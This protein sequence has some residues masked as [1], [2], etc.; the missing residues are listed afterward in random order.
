M[1]KRG[2]SVLCH[3]R[4]AQTIGVPVVDVLYGDAA[5]YLTCIRFVDL[6]IVAFKNYFD[7]WDCRAGTSKPLGEWSQDPEKGNY[8]YKMGIVTL[9]VIPYSHLN[10]KLFYD[11]SLPIALL[12][13]CV[14]RLYYVTFSKVIFLREIFIKNGEICTLLEME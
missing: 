5:T 14:I 11:I 2:G 9:I 13:F 10:K 1:P 12:T 6:I 4:R 3:Y 7:I 8:S